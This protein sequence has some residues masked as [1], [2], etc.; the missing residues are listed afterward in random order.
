MAEFISKAIGNIVNECFHT[1]VFPN[2]LKK[3]KIVPVLLKRRPLHCW[4]GGGLVCQNADDTSVV[5]AGSTELELPR[6]C[7][8][9]VNDMKVWCGN[10]SLILTA[11]KTGVILFNKM[12]PNELLYVRSGSGQYLLLTASNS[13]VCIS[14]H[15]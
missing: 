14:I 4:H 1:G 12:R 10:N 11:N 5:L 15:S 9:A 6:A 3:A 13:W 7:S 8:Q 2:V